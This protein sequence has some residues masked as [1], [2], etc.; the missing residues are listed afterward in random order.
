MYCN[1]RNLL[2]G[3]T[4]VASLGTTATP[5]FAKDAIKATVAEDPP[6]LT[7]DENGHGLTPG[8]YAI[9]TLK[10]FQI[11]NDD[12]WPTTLGTV[13]VCFDVEEG[14]P[15]PAT[16]YPVPIRL[17]QAGGDLILAPAPATFYVNNSSWADCSDIA[18]SVPQSIID[19]PDF[20]E[21]GTQLL[22][23][24]Q[25]EPT[26]PGKHLDTVTTI[27]IYAT[28]IHPTASCLQTVAFPSNQG[29][30]YDL[31]TSTSNIAVDYKNPQGG[32]G[33]LVTVNPSQMR[34]NVLVLNSCVEQKTFDL[35]LAV[36]SAFSVPTIGQPVKTY[37]FTNIVNG[38]GDFP[39]TLPSA[40]PKGTV[41]ACVPGLSVDPNHTLY[42]TV[43]IG[44]KTSSW[45]SSSALPPLD[46]EY[47]GF[48]ADVLTNAGACSGSQHPDSDG[49]ATT[50]AFIRAITCS[51]NCP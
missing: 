13:R 42:T 29:L 48:T 25:I 10:V 16:K 41:F 9:G 51:R 6:G 28:L 5:L 8:T 3:V 1:V 38:L 50:S 39:S 46:T 22:A 4:V 49:Q 24:L 35:A 26:L 31:S 11:V 37:H 2:M 18:V 47:S 45:T 43:D 34:Y 32:S 21:D 15:S 14:K 7:V 20:N 12:T 33:F 36:D 40:T 17:R 30:D 23:N 27:K 44:L 19:D